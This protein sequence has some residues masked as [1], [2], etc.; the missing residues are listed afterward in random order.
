MPRSAPDEDSAEERP[1]SAYSLDELDPDFLAAG[2]VRKVLSDREFQYLRE[3]QRIIDATYTI[4]EREGNL[5]L[6]LR[7]ILRLTNLSAPAFYRYF[8]S[9]DDLLRVISQNGSRRLLTYVSHRMAGAPL[10]QDQLRE[11]ILGLLVQA[12]YPAV[13]ARTR[14]FI[15]DQYRIWRLFP[16]DARASAR[17]LTELLI[18]PIRELTG[19]DLVEATSDA[20][21]IYQLTYGTLSE[22]LIER[23][24]P[25]EDQ[26]ATLVKFVLQAIG[27][28]FRSVEG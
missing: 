5:S 4:I 7:E 24:V 8:R 20:K 14:P 9:K 16:D 19:K 1:G 26:I 11:W 18:Q 17:D 12:T 28:S 3:V 25:A 10:P 27:S 13:A 22:L 15:E 6:S 2:L 21:A 23:Q